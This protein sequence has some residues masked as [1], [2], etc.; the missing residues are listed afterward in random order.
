[1]TFP[2]PIEIIGGGLAGLARGR[3]RR[4]AVSAGNS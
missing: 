4:R 1:M 2:R 3:A